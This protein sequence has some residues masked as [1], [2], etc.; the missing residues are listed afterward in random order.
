MSQSKN[1]PLKTLRD[2][3]LK[4]SIWLNEH[5]DR[6]FYAVTFSRSYKKAD[7][8]FA[9]AQSYAGA[10]LLKLSKLAENAYAQALAFREQARAG[11]T[12]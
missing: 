10:E 8:T 2:G 5:E 3:A 7:G 12:P 4:A 9:D 11:A 6:C 1:K